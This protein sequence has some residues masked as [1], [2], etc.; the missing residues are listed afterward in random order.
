MT[1]TEAQHRILET[2]GMRMHIAEQGTGPTVVLCHGF[3]ECWYSR[4]RSA[5][6]AGDSWFSCGRARYA[7]LRPDRRPA[8]DRTLHMLH[9]VG[10]VVGL[11]DL[12]RNPPAILLRR[13]VAAM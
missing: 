13:R 6:R 1:M 5:E 12:L 3:P 8:R 4:R 7:R 10:D 11:L 2:N 9:M